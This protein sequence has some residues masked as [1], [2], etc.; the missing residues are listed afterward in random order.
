MKV[1]ILGIGGTF[2][3][4]AALLA[5]ALGHEVGGCDGAL[6]PPMSEV[7]AAA[8]IAVTVGYDPAA[9]PADCDCFLV[10]N[11]LSRGNPAVEY[12][13][14]RGLPYTSGPQFV[15]ERVL[16]GRHVIAVAGTHGKTT[17][18]S[19][20]AWLLEATGRDPGFL[21]GG[22]PENFAAPVRLGGGECFVIEADEYDTAFFDK[23]AK[24]V[25]YRPRTLVLTNLEYDHADIYPDLAAI[26][27]QFHHLVRTVPGAGRIVANGADAALARVL[28]MGCWTPVEYFGAGAAARLAG[29]MLGPDRFEVLR[30]GRQAATV[31]WV[32]RGTHNME[33]ALAA[34]AAV[35]TVGVP[36]ADA[37]AALARFRGVRR[38]LTLRMEAAGLRLFDDFA[39]HPTA[40]A[41]TL[42]GLA[43]PG[44]R[45]LVVLEPRSRSMRAGAHAHGLAAAL[46]RADRV[47]LLRRP[48]LGWDPAEVLAALGAR[49]VTA[50]DAD[51][52]LA[53][54]LA[55][56]RGGDDVVIMSNGGFEGVPARLERA[57]A[58]KN[59]A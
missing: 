17:T 54:V 25:H 11:V 43:E 38:R 3:A 1:H 45:R 41:R 8:G 9:L 21:I 20:I 52:L 5:R 36:L 42:E 16:R 29:R 40:I 32:L 7:L 13:L 4:G 47:F 14:D 27:R 39:H 2:M 49:L 10:G 37:A 58:A 18:A 50:T 23:R 31:H 55:E 48:D 30:D 19:L 6:Y 24:F 35:E 12:V 51:Q 33:N 53:A 44:R 46:A 34:L 57:L 56:V 59:C 26:E 15:A 28:A 22:L